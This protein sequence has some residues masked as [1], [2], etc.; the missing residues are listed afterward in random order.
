MP[1]IEDGLPR[2][3]SLGNLLFGVLGIPEQFR[4]LVAQ[5]NFDL[6]MYGRSVVTVVFNGHGGMRKCESS[7]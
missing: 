1:L 4:A 3:V 6:E 7:S 5:R 2:G